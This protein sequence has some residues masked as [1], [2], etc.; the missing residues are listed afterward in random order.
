MDLQLNNTPLGIKVMRGG[1]LKLVKM[2]RANAF[3]PI[4]SMPSWRQIG[5]RREQSNAQSL[6]L[7][8]EF[9]M[10]I[11]VIESPQHWKEPLPI[12]TR[13]SHSS[14]SVNFLRWKNAFSGID[15]TEGSTRT[16]TT[17]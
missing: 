4:V 11:F 14:T 1:T 6:I 13:P 9:G 2:Q 17:L 8:S 7:L 10:L 5:V 16:R 15:V 3:S 12:S